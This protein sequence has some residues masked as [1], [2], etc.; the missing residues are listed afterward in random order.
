MMIWKM[1]TSKTNRKIANNI[2]EKFPKG[3]IFTPSQARRMIDREFH[4]NYLPKTIGEAVKDAVDH[5]VKG[6]DYGTVKTSIGK[7]QFVIMRT[8][9][10]TIPDCVKVQ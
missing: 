7:E 2:K 3:A 9:T 6:L 10:S 5:N 4:K 8:D 1:L